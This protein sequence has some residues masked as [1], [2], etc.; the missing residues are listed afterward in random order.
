[1]VG[2]EWLWLRWPQAEINLQEFKRLTPSNLALHFFGSQP[3]EGALQVF[4]SDPGSL[5][6][7]FSSFFWPNRRISRAKDLGVCKQPFADGTV[8]ISGT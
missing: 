1:M 8:K 6:E 4:L 3:L 7:V 2:F 5:A